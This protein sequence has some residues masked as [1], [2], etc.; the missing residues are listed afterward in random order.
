MERQTP[1]NKKQTNW[2]DKLNRKTHQT[3][4]NQTEGQTK[5]KDKLIRETN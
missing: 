1:Q 3:E 5:Q 2:K 4:E